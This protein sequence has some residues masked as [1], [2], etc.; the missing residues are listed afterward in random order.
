MNNFMFFFYRSLC[1]SSMG[2]ASAKIPWYSAESVLGCKWI[3]FDSVTLTSQKQCQHNYKCDY[4]K[5]N[6][7]KRSYVF[8]SIK[9]R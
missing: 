3:Y 7:Y 9:Y 6:G 5:E 4:S 1:E 8:S 2:T